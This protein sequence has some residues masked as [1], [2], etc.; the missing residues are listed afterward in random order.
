[1]KEFC[2]T[3]YQRVLVSP[4]DSRTTAFASIEAAKKIWVKGRGFT[5]EK[6]LQDAE[7]V[8]GDVRRLES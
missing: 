1:M 6:L 5:I 4:A 3:T 8:C 7:M 2:V